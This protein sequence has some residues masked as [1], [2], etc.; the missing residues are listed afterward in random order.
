[1]VVRWPPVLTPC[2]CKILGCRIIIYEGVEPDIGGIVL[3]EGERDSP[4]QPGLGPGNA[5]VAKRFRPQKPQHLVPACLGE[6]EGLVLFGMID[7]S[8]L[9]LGH[10]KE[11][12]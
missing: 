6:N 2:G 4:C 11:I 9:I 1:M 7:E 5:Q 3:I 12:I 8:L 10:E